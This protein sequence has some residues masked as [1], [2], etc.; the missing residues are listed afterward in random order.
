M[1][2]A[3]RERKREMLLFA[4]GHQPRYNSSILKVFSKQKDSRS[5]RGP[6]NPSIS[7]W[8]ERWFLHPEAMS[9]SAGFAPFPAEAGDAQPPSAGPAPPPEPRVLR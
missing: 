7:Y 4:E 9:S 2:A 3:S 5:S 1:P 6:V 8:G